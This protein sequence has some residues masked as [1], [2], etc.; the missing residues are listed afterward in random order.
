VFWEADA[1][2][3]FNPVRYTAFIEPGVGSL[4]NMKLKAKPIYSNPF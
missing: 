1:D 3:G 4:F 2:I